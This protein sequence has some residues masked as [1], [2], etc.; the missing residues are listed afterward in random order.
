MM[1][2]SRDV[3]RLACHELKLRFK[4]Q[5]SIPYFFRYLSIVDRLRILQHI[6]AEVLSVQWQLK[7]VSFGTLTEDIYQS[8]FG[9]RN[10]R[11]QSMGIKLFNLIY[12]DT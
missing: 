5:N 6:I 7:S 8:T 2:I 1:R 10:G 12:I 11:Y 4:I 3:G 9:S